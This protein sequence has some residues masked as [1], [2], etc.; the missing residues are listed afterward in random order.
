MGAIPDDSFYQ[1]I[2]IE[3]REALAEK[4][5][6]TYD[7]VAERHDTAIGFNQNTF[8]IGIY[9]VAAH[10]ISLVE[11]EYGLR[12]SVASRK[13]KFRVRAGEYTMACH[14]VGS[15]M[16]DNI[17]YSFP[18]ADS[19]AA[20]M[21]PQANPDQLALPFPGVDPDIGLQRSII[22]AHFGN[23]MEGFLKAYLCFPTKAFNGQIVAWGFVDPLLD[24]M[25]PGQ[26][27]S[28]AGPEGIPPEEPV[29]EYQ[30]HL[31]D[32]EDRSAGAQ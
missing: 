30:I 7:E 4:L 6:L 26:V 16:G 15:S 32:R 29:A 9:H 10:Q 22:L 2:S 1:D 12:L 20:E 19:A 14:R 13:P 23:H 27:E 3:I 17:L 11:R 18:R 24:S 21:V 25:A 28:G 5:R 8:S 31:K